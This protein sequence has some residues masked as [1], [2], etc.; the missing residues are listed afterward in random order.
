MDGD[1]IIDPETIRYVDYMFPM[2]EGVITYYEDVEDMFPGLLASYIKELEEEDLTIIFDDDDSIKLPSEYVIYF[3]DCGLIVAGV[4]E[5]YYSST[6]KINLY[7]WDP[8]SAQHL[9]SEEMSLLTKMQWITLIHCL[10]EN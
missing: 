3:L 9:P 1:E 4:E 10:I 7:Y 8:I 2:P 6:M 5:D